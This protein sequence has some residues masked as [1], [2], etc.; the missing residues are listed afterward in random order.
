MKKYLACAAA[1]SL[2]M[3]ACGDDSSS[4]AKGG[5]KGG[6]PAGKDIAHA[7]NSGVFTPW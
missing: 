6:T 4:N 2:M 1:L 5:D 3:V 7:G